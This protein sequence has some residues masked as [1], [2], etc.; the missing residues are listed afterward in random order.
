MDLLLEALE[1]L[2]AL[3]PVLLAIDGPCGA[4]K[5]TLANRLA[6]IFPD[7]AIY[8][9][10]DFFL[11][12]ALRSAERLATPGGNVDYERFLQEVLLP[13]SEQKPFTYRRY[14]CQRDTLTAVSAAPQPLA[15][16]EGSYSLH[17]A[18]RDFYDLK[19]FLDID[20]E[21]QAKRIV[22]RS[23]ERLAER[24]FREW[25]PM[26]NLYFEACGVRDASDIIL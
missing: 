26:E 19:V 14:E 1:A 18:L 11:P 9:M 20:A 2:L 10:D 22:A 21:S 12:P 7:S 13:L 24:F 25:I 17:P 5:S 23:P 8:H 6:D 15:I 3:K 4:G 16:I